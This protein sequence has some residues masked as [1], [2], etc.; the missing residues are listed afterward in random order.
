MSAAASVSVEM[1][2]SG[3]FQRLHPMVCAVGFLT[4]PPHEERA[5]GVAVEAPDVGA[6]KCV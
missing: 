4:T 6:V 2:G 1:T 3:G 5:R